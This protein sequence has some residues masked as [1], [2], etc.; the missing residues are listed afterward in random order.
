M[1]RDDA[2]EAQAW[3]DETPK[4]RHRCGWPAYYG[5]GKCNHAPDD[6]ETDDEQ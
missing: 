3:A 1:S 4:D 2:D 6:E 5:C